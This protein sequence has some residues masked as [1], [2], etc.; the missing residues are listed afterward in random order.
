MSISS[1]NGNIPLRRSFS[2]T[3]SDTKMSWL[4][5]L[6]AI[7][8]TTTKKQVAS[9]LSTTSRRQSTCLAASPTSKYKDY[10]ITDYT[11]SKNYENIHQHTHSEKPHVHD[12]KNLHCASNVSGYDS[13][14]NKRYYFTNEKT[15]ARVY[16]VYGGLALSSQSFL[17]EIQDVKTNDQ[18]IVTTAITT[19]KREYQRLTT[20]QLKNLNV[21]KKFQK[22]ALNMVFC[23]ETKSFIPIPALVRTPSQKS[24][25]PNC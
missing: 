13:Q 11:K 17:D 2:L 1:Q 18:E 16:I 22:D 19:P 12:D 24:K 25:T 20:L 7:T 23:R 15:P 21:S 9:T 10:I 6:S 14:R 5:S 3:Q 4:T 8:T